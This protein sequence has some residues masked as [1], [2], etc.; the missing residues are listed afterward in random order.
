MKTLVLLPILF[1]CQAADP[2]FDEF[3]RD[4]LK[5]ED[6]GDWKK[7]AWQKN[8][9]EAEKKA[10]ADGKPLLV[11]LIVGHLAQKGAAEC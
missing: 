1:A 5:R 10:R 7:I 9:E 8:L 2:K 3:K 6:A 11:V 4:A